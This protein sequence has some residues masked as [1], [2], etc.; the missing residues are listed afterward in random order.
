MSP[1]FCFDAIR[2]I[3]AIVIE[4]GVHWVVWARLAVAAD[5]EQCL[6]APHVPLAWTGNRTVVAGIEDGA[7]PRDWVPRRRAPGPADPAL[8]KGV[9]AKN[10][11][12]GRRS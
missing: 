7:V 5:G 9:K 11:T 3:S 10:G 8:G 4:P 1:E 2:S 12:S 6:A